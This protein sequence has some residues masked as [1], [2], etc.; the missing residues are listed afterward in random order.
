MYREGGKGRSPEAASSHDGDRL[1]EAEFQEFAEAATAFV[2][3]ASEDGAV[4]Y[5]GEPRSVKDN[6]SLT[7]KV[8][9]KWSV[10]LIL[11]IYSLRTAGFGDLKR[12]LHGI[13]SQVLS[14]KLRDLEEL[15]FVQREV[16][17][18]RPAKVRYSLS[19]K[20]ELLAQIGEPV[21]LYLRR[22]LG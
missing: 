1:L 14:K 16:I 8:F 9:S 21:I 18:S 12:L 2:K 15:G 20:G 7:K 22:S 11:A 17:Q 13:T 19:K 5:R 6:V 4:S 3:R 10:E